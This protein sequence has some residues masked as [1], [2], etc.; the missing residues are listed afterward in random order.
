VI[1]S[2][3]T[4][5][6]Q[7]PPSELGLRPLPDAQLRVAA[8]VLLDREEDASEQPLMET[9]DLADAL[10]DL[11]AQSSY[12]TSM[13]A[14]LHSIASL[15]AATGGIRRVTYREASSLRPVIEELL[16]GPPPAL[17]GSTVVAAAR[18]VGK[19]DVSG[20]DEPASMPRYF[21]TPFVDALDLA[22]PDRVAILRS[23]PHGTGVLHVLG[24]VAPAVWRAAAAASAADLTAAAITAYGSPDGDAGAHVEAAAAA[25][26]EAGVL[27]TDL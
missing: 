23:A 11:V 13:S 10:E 21:R 8:I 19:A 2:P 4:P 25:L 5:K 9:L 24:G 18:A 14:P 12:L 15:V 20:P 3:G 26:V 22:D 1:E 7:R 17:A 16:A 6:A 27:V